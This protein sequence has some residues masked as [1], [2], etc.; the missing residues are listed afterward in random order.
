MSLLKVRELVEGTVYEIVYWIMF[1]PKTLWAVA[2]K[3]KW[4]LKYI[5][6]ELKKEPD[7]R[8]N[9][10]LPPVVLWIITMVAPNIYIVDIVGL[11]SRVISSFN[12]KAGKSLAQLEGDE[13]LLA[14]IFFSL[15]LPICYMIWV[16]YKNNNPL[17]KEGLHR[18]FL[19]Q[20]YILSAAQI[21]TFVLGFMIGFINNP[22]LLTILPIISYIIIIVYQAI[23]IQ[24]ELNRERENTKIG[25]FRSFG[26]AV[27]PIVL[28]FA[29]FFIV[30]LV[31]SMG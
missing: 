5:E 7:K 23:F 31:F 8:F 1:L 10:Y 26:L 4:A 29:I 19:A 25:F 30:G 9:E 18:V 16:E 14:G 27:V 21:V 6:D 22:F 17:Q 2:R 13:R 28:Y 20:C 12:E 15:V 3:P 24:D 11:F